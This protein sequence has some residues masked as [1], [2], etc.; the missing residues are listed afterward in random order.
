MPMSV[1]PA[2]DKNENPNSAPASKYNIKVYVWVELDADIDELCRDH[3][4]AIEDGILDDECVAVKPIS[5][6]ASMNGSERA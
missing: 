5:Q 6:R 2:K 1:L 3:D 4:V